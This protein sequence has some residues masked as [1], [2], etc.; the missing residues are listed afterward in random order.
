MQKV[1]EHTFG[2]QT[3]K[4]S[5]LEPEELIKVTEAGNGN[6]VGEENPIIRP[7]GSKASLKQAEDVAPSSSAN[8][9]GVS[10]TNTN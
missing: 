9:D 4:K 5:L 6:A 1:D 2:H 10:A 8:E 3:S 7:S